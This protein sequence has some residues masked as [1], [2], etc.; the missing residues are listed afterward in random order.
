S[1]DAN[2][3]AIDKISYDE[4]SELL[5]A[6]GGFATIGPDDVVEIVYTSGTT[7]D[8]KCVIH[9]HRNI[10]ANLNPFQREID[11]YKKWATP[12]QPIRLLTLLPL[13]HMFGQSQGL[14]IPVLL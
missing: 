3:I 9:R 6:T 12:F 5:A 4:I 14:F 1:V 13:S 7:C 8:P 11:K 10:C 2:A